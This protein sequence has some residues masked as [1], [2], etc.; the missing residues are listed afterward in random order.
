VKVT[1]DK[2]EN[3]QAYLTVE[4]EQ[5]ELEEG[6]KKA[7]FRLVQK[8][9]VPGF[10]KGKAPRPILEQYLGKG[11]L[12]E[13]AVEHMA[14]GAFEKAAEQ[15]NIKAIAQPD[16]QLEKIEP[17]IYK[18]VVPLEPTVKLGDYK[19]I[20]ITQKSV[21]LKEEDVTNTI[22]QLRHQHAIWEPAE[23]TVDTADMINLDIESHVGE[24]PYINQKDAQF[25]VVKDSDFP[26]KGFSEQ[27]I[28]LKKE[29][30]KEFKLSFPADY[31]R[32]E[33][34]GKEVD[35]KVA[36]KEVKVEKMPEL[37]DDFAK[38][39]NA[40]YT[41]IDLL[42]TK[43]KENLLKNLEDS[44]RKEFEQKIIDE[45]VNGSQVEYP[46]VMEKEEIDAL[47][48]Q[49]MRR[50]Q[51]DE[52]GMEEYLKS[53]K[54]TAEQLREDLK[55][56]AVKNIKQSLVLTELAR[57]ESIKVE[58]SDLKQEIDTMVKDI[59]NGERKQ[60][61]IELLSH[62]Q[63]QINIASQIATRHTIAR[64]TELVNSS[65]P[66]EDKTEDSAAK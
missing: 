8:Y 40:E 11:A 14:S 25:Q 34:A 3:R 29:D 46:P 4:M 36:I 12:L 7:Y 31:N 28:G 2:T 23:K 24:Q 55:P 47:I 45:A 37:N 22:E 54:K 57:A 27:L 21:E 62:P 42:K 17:V 15:Q 52:K 30:T 20:Q 38:Q 66:T 64:L 50:W 26:I 9:V 1:L 43:V 61:L 33:L 13:D 10:R 63:N 6:L 65:K 60:K 58:Q 41:S 32:A 56:L 19:A 16:I 18:M 49:Q 51:T 5:P 59:E 48:S 44:A 53:I 39:V 35:F